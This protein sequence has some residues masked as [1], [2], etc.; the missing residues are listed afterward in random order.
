[1]RK[2]FVNT[3]C[4]LAEQNQRIMLLTGDLGFMVMEPFMNRFPERFINVGVAE[5]NLV[6]TATGLAEA[7]L[8]PY[9]YSIVPFAVLRPYEFIRNGPIYHRLQVRI[10]GAGGGVEYGNDGISHF[11]IDDVG[12]LRVQPGISIFA[13][14]DYQQADT[15]F[16][17]TWDLPGP[18]YYRLSKDEKTIIP[19]LAGQFEVGDAQVVGN[20][21]DLLFIT[22]GAAASEAIRAMEKLETLGICGTLMIASSINPPPL[23]K[24][25]EIIPQFRTALTVE[26]HYTNGGLGSLICEFVAE[27]NMD[28]RV[29]RCGLDNMPNG[30]IGSQKYLHE[31]YGISSDQ[32]VMK[33]VSLVEKRA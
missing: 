4:E 16:R 26:A 19:G 24:L 20:G 33:A 14:A 9:V 27:R 29:V 21:K 30:Q 3:L 7:G 12:V 25:E 2:T 22:L 10:V 1:M 13:P 18:I 32:L 6:G 11:G 31:R 28:C 5:Q 8:I 23:A 15:V 17:K